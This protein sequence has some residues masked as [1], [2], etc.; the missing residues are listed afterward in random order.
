MHRHTQPSPPSTWGTGQALDLQR[1]APLVPLLARRWSSQPAPL[2]AALRWPFLPSCPSFPYQAVTT[3]ITRDAAQPCCDFTLA[4]GCK[5]PYNVGFFN[6]VLL[7]PAAAIQ[8]AENKAPR[9]SGPA[10][11]LCAFASDWP[12]NTSV[13]QL[14][15]KPLCCGRL[16]ACAPPLRQRRGA[17]VCLQIH[18]QFP[19]H[20]PPRLP[21]GASP[22][23]QSH[24]SAMSRAATET[25]P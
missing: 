5:C 25:S 3:E 18:L 4:A 15:W 1:A 7:L 11:W 22:K 20:V 6:L 19:G 8:S 16:A 13:F 14:Y 10:Q 12:N 17:S 23:G 2:S 21:V 9:L 24:G